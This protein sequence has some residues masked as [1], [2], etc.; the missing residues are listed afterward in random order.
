MVDCIRQHRSAADEAVDHMA[1]RLA[2]PESGH[3]GAL[4]D[5]PVG[6][7]EMPVDLVGRDLDLEDH[8]RARLRSRGYGDQVSSSAAMVGE[9][10]FEL[11]RLA[12]PAPK[13][14]ASAVPPLALGS[15][16][17]VSRLEV[18]SVVK[19][20]LT[21][22][23]RIPCVL[24]EHGKL[25]SPNSAIAIWRRRGRGDVRVVGVRSVA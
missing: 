9:A 7:G 5:V 15:Y 20:P 16:F 19:G 8:L 24:L 6:G 1:W 23:G 13:A 3:P 17:R 12:T 10:R 14:G 2:G 22:S 18:S 11:A 4:G 21:A 25:S